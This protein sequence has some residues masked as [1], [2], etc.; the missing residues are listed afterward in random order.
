MADIVDIGIRVKSQDAVKATQR[1]KKMGT[2]VKGAGKEID[3]LES[4]GKASFKG[5]AAAAAGLL[6][7]LGGFRILQGITR[8]TAQFEDMAVALKI[9][10]GSAMDGVAAFNGIKE[11]A[12]TIPFGVSDVTKAFIALKSNGVEPTIRTLTTMADAASI[13]IT[14]LRAFENLVRVLQ[15]SAGGGLSLEELEMLGTAGIPYLKIFREEL[16]LGRL[17]I[18]K[19]GQTAEGSAQ[20]IDALFTG[21]EK[22]FSGAAAARMSELSG[23]FS[24]FRDTVEQT[25]HA[26]G[27]GF[28]QELI[29]A[30]SVIA[31]AITENRQEFEA[32]GQAIGSVIA[33]LTKFGVLAVT[34]EGPM[35][36]LIQGFLLLTGGVAAFKI[37]FGGIGWV[38]KSTLAGM[39]RAAA[40]FKA[41]ATAAK[42]AAMSVNTLK[43]AQKA[44]H[45]EN[46][47][48]SGGEMLRNKHAY[49]LFGSP[50]GQTPAEYLK[51]LDKSADITKGKIARLTDVISRNTRFIRLAGVAAVGATVGYAAYRGAMDEATE[52]GEAM[53]KSLGGQL[54][55]WEK[56]R[57]QLSAMWGK[58]GDWGQPFREFGEWFEGW[59]DRMAAKIEKLSGIKD[60]FTKVGD[61]FKTTFG[62]AMEFLAGRVKKGNQKQSYWE[63]VGEMY[64]PGIDDLRAARTARAGRPARGSAIQAAGDAAAYE[65]LLAM[66]GLRNEVGSLAGIMNQFNVSG[67]GM[68]SGITGKWTPPAP[69]G[70]AGTNQGRFPGRGT[71][72]QSMAE[73]GVFRSEISEATTDMFRNWVDG[74]MSAG[75]A[76]RNFRRQLEQDFAVSMLERIIARPLK[77][78]ANNFMDGLWNSMFGGTG[79][80]GTSGGFLPSFHNGGFT[81]NSPRLGGMDGR[82]GFLAMVRGGEIFADV[83]KMKR[84]APPSAGKGGPINAGAIKVEINNTISDD[85]RVRVTQGR[86]ERELRIFVES[87]VND[88]FARRGPVSKTLRS[89]GNVRHAQ[90]SDRG[91]A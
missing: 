50:R 69:P 18:G 37:A 82:G 11:F 80:P 2:E 20:L 55:W 22:R 49:R 54:T 26:I 30:T 16:G 79:V 86:T 74:S 5:L 75:A 46:L 90:I 28:K 44:L 85:A 27:I 4:R 63:Q 66:R 51:V 33:G 58:T 48:L 78:L 29:G 76:V 42:T 15:R 8:T 41:T 57:T 35:G 64:A 9:V 87:V 1:V 89:Q 67:S 71:I 34:G 59:T 39:G 81:G 91:A 3:K 68:T 12:K 45:T 10:T 31:D 23:T 60:F 6:T 32:L 7:T 19:F 14:P 36:K 88:S 43:A 52:R 61:V 47:I 77:N 21:L 17:E 83:S 25:A 13:S 40:S 38:V 70:A 56:V 84:V 73:I 72:D 62:P 53:Q 24:N 65:T